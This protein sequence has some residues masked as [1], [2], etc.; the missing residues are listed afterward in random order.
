MAVSSLEKK[1][2]LAQDAQRIMENKLREKE[3]EIERLQEDRRFLADREKEER[4]EKEQ[5]RLAYEEQK[6]RI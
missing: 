5:E 6:V 1:L 2:L 4:E 3:I